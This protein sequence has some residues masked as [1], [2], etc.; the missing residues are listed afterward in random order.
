MM[1]KNSYSKQELNLIISER[2]TRIIDNASSIKFENKYYVPVDND[3]GEI[4]TYMKRTE[5][6]VIL[7]Y[8]AEL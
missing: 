7:T 6:I 8:D 1:K 5:C 3:T 2:T 4:I